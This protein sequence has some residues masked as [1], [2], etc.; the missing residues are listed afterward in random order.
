MRRSSSSE[1]F[2]KSDHR[3]FAGVG[4]W[5][6]G[7][8]SHASTSTEFVASLELP[9]EAFVYPEGWQ[10]WTPTDLYAISGTQRVPVDRRQFELGYRADRPGPSGRPGEFVADG[11][12]ALVDPT[13]ATTHVF[14]A[15]DPSRPVR[16]TATYRNGICQVAAD[17]EIDQTSLSHQPSVGTAEPDR[18]RET[19]RAW[20]A[21]R[22]WS[23]PPRP[24][25]T[26]WCSWYQYFT[27]VTQADVLENLEAMDEL[28]LD[29]EVVQIDDG[30]QRE[31]GDWLDASERFPDVAGLV[32]QIRGR[33]RRAGIW[34]APWLVGERSRLAAEH[35]EWLVR[36]SEG[37][38][39]TAGVN[40]NQTLWVLDTDHEAARAYLYGVL[41]RFVDLGVDYL[42]LD[43]LYAGALLGVRAEGG[44]GVASYRSL[45]AAIGQWFPEVY[46]VAC[47]AP[48]LP[49]VGLVDAMRVSP[50]TAPHVQP[51]RGDFSAPGQLS[52]MVT[53]RARRWQH[54]V[55]WTND[56]DCLLARPGVEARHEWASYLAEFPGLR[57]CSDRL[58]SLD[59][60]GLGYTIKHLEC[61]TI[62]P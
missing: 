27:E 20:A 19:L 5:H 33:G 61:V 2:V 26:V 62:Q 22:R 34:V 24:A 58:R 45:L 47:G 36:T 7:E 11:L 25:P 30:Y 6:S 3:R 59:S 37:Q 12:L 50:D 28:A 18:W 38:P 44:D 1:C 10:S 9:T 23:D 14:A 52:A 31:I 39:V 43:F 55:W 32:E 13:T 17:G 15:V 48:L 42:K 57:G 4:Q 49:S 53:G 60:V 51:S 46:L 21:D 35:P 56:P 54:G 8:V 40:W 41:A 16:L 29:F